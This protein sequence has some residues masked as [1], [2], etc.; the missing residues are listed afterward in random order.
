M[1]CLPTSYGILVGVGGSVASDAAIRFATR[2][3]ILREAPLTLMHVI[4]P[5]PE[6]GAPSMHPEIAAAW[7][8]N[9]RHVV[10]QARKTTVAASG[11]SALVDVRN[12]IAY[13]TAATAV[14]ALIDASSRAQMIVVGSRGMGAAG[15][16]VLGSVSS[17]LVQHARCPVAVIHD[18]D[19]SADDK[20][21]VLV[22]VDGSPAAEAAVAL[23][24]DE[25]SRRRVHLVA[26]HA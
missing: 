22:G 11:E 17:G 10:E 14:C 24:F 15:R 16:F 12:E 25:A 5:I 2:E 3:A 13:S 21:P 7:E 23:A 9:A 4:S 8:D 20:A 18:D 19:G 6:W 26:L 1:T